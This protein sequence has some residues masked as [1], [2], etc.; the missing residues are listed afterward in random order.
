M[1][2]TMGV[3]P[4]DPKARKILF[5]TYWRSTGWKPD[6]LRH[7]AP[8]DLAYARSKGLMFPRYTFTH[9]KLLKDLHGAVSALSPKQVAGAFLAS[10]STRRNDLRSGLATYTL[11]SQLKP[12]KFVSDDR[13]WCTHCRGTKSEQDEDLDVLNFERHKWGGV[14][15]EQPLYQYLDL[16]A[17]RAAL[18]ATPEA[19]DLAIFAKILKTIEASPA[20][21]GASKLEKRLAD[22]LPSSKQERNQ[23]LEILALSGV[24]APKQER[25]SPGEWGLAGAWRGVDGY[26]KRVVARLFGGFMRSTTT[27]GGRRPARTS[28]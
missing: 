13:I 9:D 3:T 15:H 17:L 10:L 12:H 7:T 2:R 5:E 16:K 19:D 24:M 20:N 18:P 28:R 11:A 4:I 8:A 14:R 26:D 25:K 23:L 27:R 22:V 21:D 6:E 1:F